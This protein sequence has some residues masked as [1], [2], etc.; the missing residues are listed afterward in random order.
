MK[1][2][3]LDAPGLP[4]SLRIGELPDPVPSPNEVLV[5]VQATS[6]N[7]VDFKVAAI[8]SDL[9]TYPHVLGVDAAGIIE[10]VGA[11][12]SD[13]LPGDRVFYHT[14]WRRPG[15]Y[16]ELNTVPSHTIAR[17]PESVNYVDAAAIPCAG[18]TAYS[19]LYRRLHAKSGDLVL[20][21]SGSGGVGGFAIQLAKRAGATVVTTCSAANTDYVRKL[22]ADEVVDY[23]SEN[24]FERARAIAG[25]RLFDAIIDTI[26]PKN[27]VD[28]LRLLAP[29][30]GV[31]FI[32]GLPDLS[33][34][35]DL[36]YSIAIHDI[37]L[38]GVLVAPPFRRQQEDLAKM[39]SEMIALVQQARCTPQSH[40][41]Y[42]WN[43]FREAW[44]LW[45]KDMSE[46]RSLLSWCNGHESRSD[47]SLL[48]AVVAARARRPGLPAVRP[49]ITAGGTK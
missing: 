2:I 30:G 15:P 9:W 20:V 8:G 11:K 19:S 21:H 5:R 49:M 18:L 16:A 28:N 33:R 1:A 31:A 24:V 32:A 25:P 40:G 48:K 14:T 34:L 39:A 23:R 47:R 37:G 4:S 36:P 43:I 12:V 45:P 7:P 38:G 41:S 44:P 10:Q 35:D 6:L 42:H 22:G 29:E 27:G 26:G 17:I 3:L 13:W 46:A